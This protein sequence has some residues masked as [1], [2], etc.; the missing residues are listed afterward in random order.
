MFRMYGKS[1]SD[2]PAKPDGFL[3]VVG[4]MPLDAMEAGFAACVNTCS[5]FPVPHDVL[6]A[7][8]KWQLEHRDDEST[9]KLL[10][11]P[12]KPVDFQPAE[13]DA[14]L[15][16]LSRLRGTTTKDEIAQWLEEGKAK[17]RA[18]YAELAKDPKWQLEQARYG[19]PEYRHL[20]SGEQSTIPEDPGERRSWARDKAVKNGWIEA[21]EAER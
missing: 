18:R 17:A 7:A 12:D 2:F 11:R 16:A 5:E 1:L 4:H 19:V 6:N 21:R 3:A 10:D 20:L 9:Q 13:T 8:E 15:R 14:T